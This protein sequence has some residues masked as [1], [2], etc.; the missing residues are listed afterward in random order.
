[1]LPKHDYIYEIILDLVGGKDNIG[2][3]STHD[4]QE[5]SKFIDKVIN[6]SYKVPKIVDQIKINKDCSFVE[7]I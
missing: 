3:D 7:E 1:M 6:G 4:E 5:L 2:I